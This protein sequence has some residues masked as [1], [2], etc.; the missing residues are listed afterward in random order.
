MIHL[1][2]LF[3][4][5]LSVFDLQMYG[6]LWIGS[7]SLTVQK[8]DFFVYQPNPCTGNPTV[9]KHLFFCNLKI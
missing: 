8:L 2:T 5:S 4:S 9:N 3:K 7:F 6:L 1:C